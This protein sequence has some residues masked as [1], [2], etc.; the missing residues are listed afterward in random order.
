M[1]LMCQA[2]ARECT[3]SFI[4]GH[5]ANCPVCCVLLEEVVTKAQFKPLA[6]FMFLA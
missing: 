2:A 4:H 6:R 3:T 1:A 5:C